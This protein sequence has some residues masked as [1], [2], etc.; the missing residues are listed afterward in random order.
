[1]PVAGGRIIRKLD[2]AEAD[3]LCSPYLSDRLADLGI[4]GGIVKLTYDKRES[5]FLVVTEYTSPVKLT[6]TELERLTRET[7]EQWSDGVGEGGFDKLAR[8]L[9]VAIDL[10]VDDEE[11]LKTEQID[12]GKSAP[13]VKMDLAKA[14]RKGDLAAVRQHLDAGADMEARMQGCT[15]L[16]WA[17][18]YGR[19][20]VVAELIARGANLKARDPVGEDSLMLAA[21]SRRM[22]DATS[23]RIAKM[24][25][26]RGVSVHGPQGPGAD[27][28]LGQTTPLYIARQHNRSKLAAVL[29]E[30]G[31][32]G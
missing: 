14:A 20:E 2:G 8:R 12:D 18:L 27:P 23:A 17:V 16:H 21:Q 11:D 25:L 29:E 30:F 19:V 26:E 3:D 15:A 10:S 6:P 1:M 31:A 4:L 5:R 24:L 13:R 28:R 9:N 32:V 22:S 7:A